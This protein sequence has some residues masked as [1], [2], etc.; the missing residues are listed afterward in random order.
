MSVDRTQIVAKN[1]TYSVACH[2]ATLVLHFVVRTFFIKCL[3][4]EY[5]GIQGLFS[6]ILMLLSLADLGMVN[7]MNFSLYGPLARNDQYK[8]GQIMLFFKRI[9]RI[10]AIVV[11]LLGIGLLP[12]LDFFL[13]ERPDIP[14]NLMVIYLFFVFN[15]AVSYLFAYK[16]TLIIA[17]QRKYIVSVYT[18]TVNLFICSLQCLLLYLFRSFYSYLIL[19]VVCTIMTNVLIAFKCNKD[20]PVLKEKGIKQIESEEKKS[21]FINIKS[22]FLYRIGGVILNGT[23]NLIISKFFN[24]VVLGLCSNVYY[25]I[26]SINGIILQVLLSFLATL[27]NVNAIESKEHKIKVF[28]KTSLFCFWLYGFVCLACVLFLNDFINIWIGSN[29]ILDELALF[30]IVVVFFMD[31][32]GF[33]LYAYRS[34]MGLFS[35]V[36]YAP[37]IASVL[38]ILFAVI[39]LKWI[40]VAGVYFAIALSRFFCINCTDIFVVFKKGLNDRFPYRFFVYYISFILLLTLTYLFTIVIIHNIS[41][42]NYYLKLVC[43]I[44]IYTLIF[45]VVFLVFFRRSSTFVELW[46]GIK[47][48]IRKQFKII[49]I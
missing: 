23:S 27:G 26:N 22:L 21:I 9:Y 43:D 34:T 37:I 42:N 17:D 46:T 19:M 35:T 33:P 14:E 4:I 40:G 15:S 20:Y 48:Q 25:L 5:V 12:F 24:I 1:S 44:I 28:Y 7:A 29:Y 45:H 18:F 11:F 39:L 36:K 2:C 31:G 38:N 8:I 47:R 13:S 41:I 6:N 32:V 49:K 16:Q 10:I 3:S 30:S